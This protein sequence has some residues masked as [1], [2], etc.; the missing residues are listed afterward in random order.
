MAVLGVVNELEADHQVVSSA[1]Y[2]AALRRMSRSSF[3]RAFSR[4]SWR[5]RS[6]SVTDVGVCEAASVL[7]VVRAP[8]PYLRT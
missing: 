1:K 6:A 5:I 8:V 7:V 2:F 4:S 3:S